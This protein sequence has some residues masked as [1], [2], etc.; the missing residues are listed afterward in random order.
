MERVDKLIIFARAPRLGQVKTR[1]AAEVGSQSALDIYSQ[2]LALLLESLKSLKHV[3]IAFAPP[4]AEAELR[5]LL[6]A[7]WKLRPQIEGT[8]DARLVHAF[9]HAFSEGASKV[10]I[11]GSDCPYVTPHHIRQGF[12]ALN[13]A[14]AVFGPAT[15]GGYWLVALKAPHPE[16]F[17]DIPWSTSEVLARSLA[18]AR[19]SNLKLDLLEILSDVDT[20]AD[21]HAFKKAPPQKP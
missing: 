11:I 3:E 2:L 17:Q 12:A 16:L 18:N 21:W 4:D 10:A 14:D 20:K 19:N 7:S 1:L 8:L 5:P 6:P 9:D 15:D 13:Q